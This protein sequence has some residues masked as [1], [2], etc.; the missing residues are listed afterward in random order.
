MTRDFTSELS[1][2]HAERALPYRRR[3][4]TAWAIERD[5]VNVT[6][7]A[8]S[9]HLQDRADQAETRRPHNPKLRE[10]VV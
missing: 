3:T 7:A 8:M 2:L 4:R 5:I 10:C 9:E 6:A 1:A